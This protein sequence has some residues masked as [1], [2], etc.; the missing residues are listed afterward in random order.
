MIDEVSQK[1]YDKIYWCGF[2]VVEIG[3]CVVIILTDKELVNTYHHLLNTHLTVTGF[4]YHKNPDYKGYS[5]F[6]AVDSGGVEY[7][8]QLHHLTVISKVNELK[9]PE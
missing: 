2:G 1:R 3:A 6:A 5:P 8:F 9:D 7:R 4:Y